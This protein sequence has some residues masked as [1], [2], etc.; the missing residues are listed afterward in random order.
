VGS[1]SDQYSPDAA[2]M[3]TKA[4]QRGSRTIFLADMEKGT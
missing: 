1:G 4:G 3:A 2:S